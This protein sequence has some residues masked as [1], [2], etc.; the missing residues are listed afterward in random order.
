MS[1]NT[2][3]FQQIATVLNSIV[4]QATGQDVITPT[5]TAEFVSVAN[6]ALS[7][8][9]DVIMNAI[10]SVLSRTIFSIRP[11]SAKF[12]GLEKDLP[13]WGAYMRKLSIADSD[14]ADDDAYKY[15]VTY[16]ANENPPTGDGGM[17]DQWKIKKPNVLQTNFY[18]ASVFSDHVTIF[19]DQLESAFR[20]PEELGSF[21]SLIMTNLS[22]RIEMSRDAVAR[23]LVANMIGALLTEN[24][25]NRVIHLLTEYNAQTGLSLTAQSVYAPDNFPAFMKWVYSRVAQISDLMTE[26]SLMFQTVITGKPVLR[27]T[28][29]QNQK[30]YLFSPARHQMDARVLADTYH[31][32]YLKYADVES[33]NYWQSI[34]APDSVNISPA[35]TSTA[36]AV[37]NGDPVSKSGIFGLMFDEDAMGYALLDRRMV[38]TPVNASGL[39]RNIFVHAKQKVFMDNTEKAVVLLLD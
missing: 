36:G 20:S 24:D 28:P 9:N 25:S 29:M 39:Y 16:D 3:T 18:G 21:I 10:S 11:Y 5:N 22:N 8:G 32:N 37:V 12:V 15:P 19:E 31:D 4:H 23:G 30:I 34:K 14:W 27:H 35:Y 6:T 33:V 38:P 2:M 17:V 26:N 1:V 13:R 7:L